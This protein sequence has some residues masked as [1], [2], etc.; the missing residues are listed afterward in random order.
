[1][2]SMSLFF[3]WGDT[4]ARY[5]RS[6]LGPLWL[7]L[8]TALGT[9]GLGVVWGRLLDLDL[10]VFV[11]SLVTGLVVWQLIAGSIIEASHT[12]TK[13][14]RLIRNVK[15]P[16]LVF[17]IQVL[18]RQLI[19]F[20]HNFFV[21]IV[22]LMIFPPT[23]NWSVF[24][25]VPNFFLVALNLL[26]MILVLSIFAARYRD[27]DQLIAAAMPILF[28]LSPVIY[29][30]Y[31][32]GVKTAWVWINPFSHLISLVRYP[33]QGMVT[34]MFIYLTAAIL[35]LIGWMFSLLL[36]NKKYSRIAFWV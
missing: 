22:V 6:V 18:L 27:V 19:N 16:Y 4:V 9:L 3:A 2:F 17:P 14:S 29:Q 31:Q 33:L 10:Q 15:T 36:L 21:V 34:P 24:L 5:R 13:N 35:L 25:L 30:P 26:W 32:L 11:P 1:M 12:F 20:F 23:L 7:V 28:F 8:G